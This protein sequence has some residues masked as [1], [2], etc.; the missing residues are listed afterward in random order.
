MSLFSD[1]PQ[2]LKIVGDTT[3][4]VHHTA[5]YRCEAVNANPLPKLQWDVNGEVIHSSGVQ[6]KTYTVSAYSASGSIRSN[7]GLLGA[8]HQLNNRSSFPVSEAEAI[9]AVVSELTL[10]AGDTDTRLNLRCVAS[11]QGHRGEPMISDAKLSVF[12][13]SK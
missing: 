4:Q 9:W 12:V 13:L 6:T 8:Q 1:P 5:V 11:S 2:T 3:I 10:A 7:L